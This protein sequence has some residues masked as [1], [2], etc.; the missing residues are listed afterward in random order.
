MQKPKSVL[1]LQLT[2]AQVLTQ[3]MK[4]PLAESAGDGLAGLIQLSFLKV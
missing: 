4:L 1:P 2:M 3:D